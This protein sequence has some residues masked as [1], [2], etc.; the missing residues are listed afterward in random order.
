M[1][2]GIG[3]LALASPSYAVDSGTFN[4]NNGT[5]WAYEY[6]TDGDTPVLTIGFKT[7]ADTTN[8]VFNIPSLSEVK[9][10]LSSLSSINSIDTYYIKQLT[11]NDASGV[12]APNVTKVDMTNAAKAQMVSLAP[13]FKNTTGEVE[14]QFGNDMVIGDPDDVIAKAP[15]YYNYV[16][17]GGQAGLF[18][19]L[20]VKLTNLEKVKYIGWR[21]FSGATLNEA[22]RDITIN[23]NQTVGGYVFA[24]SNVKSLTIDAEQTG[25]GFC[26]NCSELTGLTFGD[27]AKTVYGNAFRGTTA[28]SQELD[29]NKLVELGR[30]AFESSGITGVT[31]GSSLVTL[32]DE[33]FMNTNLGSL[34]LSGAT[35]SMGNYVFMN[36]NISTLNMGETIDNI[37]NWAFFGNKIRNLSLP[38][39]I[40]KFGVAAFGDNPIDT[41][42]INFDMVDLRNI[43][44]GKFYDGS[45]SS[46]S[47]A[48]AR[49]FFGCNNG[50]WVSSCSGDKDAGV[51]LKHLVIN[52]PYGANDTAPNHY[53]KYFSDDPEYLT[54]L[55]SSAKNIIPAGFF[56]D[57][58]SL[59]SVEIAEG[60]ELIDTMAFMRGY[61]NYLG[62]GGNG[63][64]NPGYMQGPIRVSNAEHVLT[65]LSL[66]STLKAIGDSAFMWFS[67]NQKFN[68]DELPANL[69]YVGHKAFYMNAGTIGDLKSTKIQFIGD[70]AFYAGIKVNKIY[71]GEQLNYIGEL[72]FAG[73]GGYMDLTVDTDLFGSSVT[74]GN[75]NGNGN[76][77]EHIFG[78]WLVNMY[79]R[80]S[81]A[82]VPQGFDNDPGSGPTTYLYHYKKITFTSNATTEP[83][84]GPM[85]MQGIYCDTIDLSATPWESLGS[86]SMMFAKAK[87]VKLPSRLKTI[88]TNALQG[89][90]VEEE[91][92]LPETLE[93]IQ[94]LAFMQ[95]ASGKIGDV[96][97]TKFPQSLKTIQH[98]AFFGQSRVKGD[99][100]LP[101][102]VE[103]G[104]VAFARTN[105]RDITLGPSIQ[106]LQPYVF[107]ETPSV[108]NV[109]VDRAMFSDSG[110][111]VFVEAFGN[112][113]N[114][115]GRIKF[116]ENADQP[117]GG[118][119]NCEAQATEP[120]ED[121][122]GN[123]IN[124]DRK[125]AF[126]YGIQARVIDMGEMQ[127]VTTIPVS[128]FQDSVVDEVILPET[129][130]TIGE[131]AFF[132]AKIGRLNLPDSV[133]T[134]EAEAFQWTKGKLT[135]YVVPAGVKTIGRSAFYGSDLTDDLYIPSTIE[136]I[137]KDAFNAG[138]NDVHY[139][140]VSIEGDINET[141]TNDQLIHQL[142]WGSDIHTLIIHSS[143]LP[144]THDNG[145][146]DRQ[147]FWNMPLEEV[148]ITALPAIP[149]NAFEANSNLRLLVMRRDSALRS[150][151]EEA[152]ID[153]EQLHDVKF[154]SEL[155]NETVTIGDRAFSNT[156]FKTIGN[157]DA[158]FELNAAKFTV[159]DGVFTNM[160]QLTSVEIPANFN[161]GIVPSG[162]FAGDTELVEVKVDKDVA[163]V[164]SAAFS[165]NKLA[166]A[167]FWGN[168]TVLE[169]NAVPDT[170][171]VYAYTG[172]N[173]ETYASARTGTGKFYPLDEVIYITTNKFRITTPTD[174]DFDGDVTVYSLRR[175]G[176]V[177]ESDEWGE[178]DGTA[179]PR[180]QKDLYFM[181]MNSMVESDPAAGTVFDTPIAVDDLDLSNENFSNIN[182]TVGD[183][184]ENGNRITTIGYTDDNTGN[185]AMTSIQLRAPV[186]GGRGG[187]D[188]D[189]LAVLGA[190]G[191]ESTTSAAASS[192]ENS[193][194]TTGATAATTTNAESSASG[195]GNPKTG[196][197]IL[198]Y[199]ALF[200]S[201]SLLGGAAI[202]IIRHNKR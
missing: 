138:S 3:C 50:Q 7:V 91:I 57:F 67:N 123:V 1:L 165:N 176:I 75:T 164:S 178:Y 170:T 200:A 196:D 197:A 15:S 9:G 153:C 113:Q 97:I 126:F 21:A 140:T 157:E 194:E 114:R 34:D 64:Y 159:G 136:S 141:I 65:S 49:I 71:L 115:F 66:P 98:A 125:Y 10:K 60:F 166:R 107:L 139:D 5:T 134:I 172:S 127:N 61:S 189:D 143:T 142:F 158:Q 99:L 16:Y 31:I 133:E 182:Y 85:F 199:I 62:Y 36:A 188:D 173:A 87:E 18:E 169:A 53:Y 167:I 59:E 86:S 69:E 175:D 101:N 47:G 179:Y 130:K 63:A 54:N 110:W 12:A 20:S 22:N 51:H 151:G 80:P 161:G 145:D 171:D 198:G 201:C 58:D 90:Q 45:Y 120:C 183:A 89:A 149:D 150:I 105:I 52:A 44:D 137:G 77:F 33:V 55:R 154:S 13:L 106:T 38:K 160:A 186:E 111:R 26:E 103:L 131:D 152:F 195:A 2:A 102:L 4:D 180:D 108:R 32:R 132:N 184:D 93:T 191:N 6:N 28:L 119:G 48:R 177:M 185:A 117:C 202:A 122:D 118:F 82:N 104:N 174:E 76:A 23:N 121:N 73:N 83:G 144:V 155:V 187:D 124:C 96:K 193:T 78:M 25:A 56:A 39:S 128:M 43:Y 27:N 19:G 148:V 35:A 168:N 37:G 92:V 135:G 146:S 192:S 129:V 81:Y 88:E 181:N 24:E 30:A 8:T 14:L 112:K 74:R 100:N 94:A 70:Y 147:Q 84:S 190:N 68:I 95:E 41:L 29:T 40:K 163:K 17:S 11:A 42:T 46:T 79:I 72:A 162:S 116:T 156:G 109:T